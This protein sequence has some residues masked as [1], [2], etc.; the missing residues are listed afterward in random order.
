MPTV[1]TYAVT[2][3]LVC[4]LSLPSEAH[5]SEFSFGTP[6]SP[7]AIHCNAS[8][9]GFC[10]DGV[11]ADGVCICREGMINRGDSPCSYKAISKSD[12]F[13]YAVLPVL[14]SMGYP[15]F[16]IARGNGLYIFLGVMKILTAAG[17]AL[18]WIVDMILVASGSLRDG[19]GAPFFDDM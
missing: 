9:A 18:W 16:H 11:C 4:L 13:T 1:S 12:A 7:F 14:A 5:K 17:C 3:T 2:F 10:N 15:W 8:N 6:N 19:N